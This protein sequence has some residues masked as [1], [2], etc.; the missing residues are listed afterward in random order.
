MA[1]YITNNFARVQCV[2]CKAIVA[3]LLPGKAFDAITFKECKCKPTA[4]KRKRVVKKDVREN[5]EKI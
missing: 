3:E 1:K 4:P 5:T 2:T